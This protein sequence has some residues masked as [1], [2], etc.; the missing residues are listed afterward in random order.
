MQ[1]EDARVDT[2][3]EGNDTPTATDNEVM[4][5]PG[6]WGLAGAQIRAND[7]HGQHVGTYQIRRAD[8]LVMAAAPE[9][10]AALRELV[11][12]W[13]ATQYQVSD[14]L[15]QALQ[16]ADAAIAKAEGRSSK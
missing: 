9:L 7:G 13:D 1:E 14:R 15:E 4:Y 5:T 3:G 16:D 10:L 2:M 12:A 6:P 11:R 8:G